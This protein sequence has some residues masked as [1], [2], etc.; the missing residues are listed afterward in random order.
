MPRPSLDGKRTHLILTRYQYRELHTL[1]EK[2]GM[3]VSEHI[4]RAVDFYLATLSNRLS[5]TKKG[6][7]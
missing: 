6:G 2:T 7:A 1:A 4:R 5:T 3:N